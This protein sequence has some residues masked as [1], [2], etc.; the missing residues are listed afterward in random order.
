VSPP[1]SSSP[2]IGAAAMRASTADVNSSTTAGSDSFGTAWAGP[3]DTWWTRNPGSTET[4][5]G[6]P[7]AQARVNTSHD[8]PERASAAV[9]S[10]T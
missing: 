1:P 6:R 9:S 4:T 7:G 8:T 5:G 3:A 10:R 2:C